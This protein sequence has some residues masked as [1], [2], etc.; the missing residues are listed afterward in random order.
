MKQFLL[1]TMLFSLSM[2]GTGIEFEQSSWE[3]ILEQAQINQAPIFVE[4]YADYCLPCKSME[5]EVFSDVE[6]ASFF[7]QN[8]INYKVDLQSHF[9]KMF[10]VMYDVRQLPTLLFLNE[11]G[12]VI[13]Q[14]V[15]VKSKREL[16]DLGQQVLNQTKSKRLTKSKKDTRLKTNIQHQEDLNE[17]PIVESRETSPNPP[18]FFDSYLEEAHTINYKLNKLKHTEGKHSRSYLREVF[19]SSHNLQSKALD[20]VSKDLNKFTEV[21]GKQVVQEEFYHAGE[22][23]V[24]IAI[25]LQDERLIKKASKLIKKVNYPN[26][27]EVQLK[28][29]SEFFAGTEKWCDFAMFFYENREIPKIEDLIEATWRVYENGESK[30]SLKIIKKAIKKQKRELTLEE[31]SVLQ[32]HIYEKMGKKRKSRKIAASTLNRHGIGLKNQ[33]TL[34]LLL[35]RLE[36]N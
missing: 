22:K 6:L 32:A 11:R 16:I 4:V 36:A 19:N 18:V 24:Q 28:W 1:F 10:G 17:I 8:Y 2:K 33:K 25:Q 9:G 26:Y 13:E 20:I 7:N 31:Y 27:Q 21:Y 23:A 34:E 29:Y 30:R 14:T 35:E 3:V 5:S 12:E 15:G